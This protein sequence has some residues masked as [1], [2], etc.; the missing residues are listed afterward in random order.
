VNLA[1]GALA[2]VFQQVRRAGHHNNLRISYLWMRVFHYA[3]KQRF[4][5]CS[6]IG[7][8]LGPEA[9]S[10]TDQRSNIRLSPLG[11]A[12]KPR[13]GDRAQ[14]EGFVGR[15]YWLTGELRFCPT[16]DL[17]DTKCHVLS[18]GHVKIDG[19]EQGNASESYCGVTSETYFRVRFDNGRTGYLLAP[20]LMGPRG[21]FDAGSN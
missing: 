20:D 9:R 21:T 16:V 18:K 15:D 10:T 3:P 12:V 19:I 11:N 7:R 4:A 17:G 2:E 8:L 5:L 6:R 13:G 14:Y 1:A